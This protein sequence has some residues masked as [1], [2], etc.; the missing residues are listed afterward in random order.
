MAREAI[1]SDIRKTVRVQQ[2][3]NGLTIFFPEP[4]WQS[5]ECK[6]SMGRVPGV[7]LRRQTAAGAAADR[8]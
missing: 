7:E 2:I 4:G 8:G 1:A 3:V 6:R 5:Q